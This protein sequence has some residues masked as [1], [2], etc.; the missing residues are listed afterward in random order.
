MKFSTSIAVIAL[1]AALSSAE[2][3]LSAGCTTY[4][5]TLS[6]APL[7]QC[8]TYT[9]IGFSSSTFTFKGDHDTVKLQKALTDFCAKPAC[10]PDQYAGVFKDLQTNC[11]A[12]MVAANQD[13]LGA[14]MYMWYVKAKVKEKA[15]QKISSGNIAMSIAWFDFNG[16]NDKV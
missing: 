11:A 2:A 13:T 4:L 3:A 8:R 16:S 7:A 10:T 5:A 6:A 15:A 12:D 14:T 1:G 9:A